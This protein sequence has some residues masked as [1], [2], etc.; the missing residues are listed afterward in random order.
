MYLN[1]V[2]QQQTGARGKP[3][4]KAPP[5]HNDLVQCLYYILI[6]KIY[7]AMFKLYFK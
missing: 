5:P 3:V 6:N 7:T 4:N 1:V 2:A